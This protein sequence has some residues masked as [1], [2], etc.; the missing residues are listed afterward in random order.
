MSIKITG[1]NYISYTCRNSYISNTFHHYHF[2][3]IFQTHFKH[4]VLVHIFRKAVRIVHFWCTKFSEGCIHHI[5]FS[6]GYTHCTLS[7]IFLAVHMEWVIFKRLC[8][9]LLKIQPKKKQQ[10]KDKS[11]MPHVN[12]ISQVRNKIIKFN[13]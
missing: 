9:F 8:T 11:A 13:S 4:K 1:R 7:C 12:S 6:E 2:F 5:H 10:Q 3:T